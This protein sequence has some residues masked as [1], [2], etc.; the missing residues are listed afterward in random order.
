LAAGSIDTDAL[1][2]SALLDTSIL[3]PALGGKVRSTDDPLSAPFFAAMVK[4]QRRVLIA[5]PSVAE[6]MR[7][8][9]NAAIPRTR[10]VVV[11]DF[12]RIAAEHLGRDFPPN[13][14][15]SVRDELKPSLEKV[16]LDYI[17]FDAMIVACAKRHNASVLITTD[18]GQAT[19]A[20]KIGLIAKRPA[21]YQT[22]QTVLPNVT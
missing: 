19:L 16:S 7:K 22:P 21:D 4:T 5:A 2:Y 6:L 9:S 8:A 13:V 1:P 3:V 17:K 10:G 15:K 18:V 12:D 11:V 20:K 14:L